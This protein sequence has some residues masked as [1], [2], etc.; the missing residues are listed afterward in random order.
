MER[1]YIIFFGGRPYAWRHTVRCGAAML[2]IRR[3]MGMPYQNIA[4]I[5]IL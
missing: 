5:G 4:Q 3:V 1:L 2:R